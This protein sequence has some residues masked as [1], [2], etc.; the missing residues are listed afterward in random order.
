MIMVKTVYIS[1]PISGYNINDRI[2]AFDEVERKLLDKGFSVINP[3]CEN[4]YDSN[5]SYGQYMRDD[6]KLLLDCDAIYLMQEWDKS[7][8]CRTEYLVA[9]TCGIE[10][11]ENN[12]KVI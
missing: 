11:I 3:L 8:G 5:K 10:I 2:K 9:L 6:L 12:N 4:G 7:K 1:G